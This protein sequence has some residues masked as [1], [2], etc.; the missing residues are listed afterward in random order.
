MVCVDCGSEQSNFN[1]LCENCYLKSHPIVILRNR[2]KLTLC[3]IC[4]TPVGPSGNWDKQLI[5]DQKYDQLLNAISQSIQKKYKLA[6]GISSLRIE[7]K[8]FSDI[9][10]INNVLPN[11][12]E[13]DL[14]ITASPDPFLPELNFTETANVFIKYRTCI[15]CQNVGQPTTI[16]GKLQIRG[17]KSWKTEINKIIDNFVQ[18]YDSEKKVDF[19]PVKI[20]ELKDGIDISFS[21]KN[22]VEILASEFQQK[23]ATQNIKTDETISYDHVKSK[24]KQ[25]SV[26][27]VRLPPY[28]L[29]D[30]IQGPNKL[31]QIISIN[32]VKSKGYDYDKKKFIDVDSS[33][34]WD[35]TFHLFLPF[36]N[37]KKFQIINL[38]NYN[39][40]I[41]L[42]DLETFQEYEETL[43]SNLIIGKEQIVLGFIYEKEKNL[44]KRV[45]FNFFSPNN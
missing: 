43:F 35:N 13:I 27:S 7:L 21:N 28:K 45:C 38:D 39:K 10:S 1:F 42:M 36:E 30:V 23:F 19:L 9:I 11:I 37:L 26:I 29:G 22:S 32:G 33:I 6:K 12:V 40:L 2:I 15:H 44:Y 8:D 5:I 41:N 24:S 16:N 17:L 3:K 4:Q 34:L 31:L 25:R 20:E 18:K 14:H